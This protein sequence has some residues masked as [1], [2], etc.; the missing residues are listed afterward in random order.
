MQWMTIIS[1]PASDTRYQEN[2]AGTLARLTVGGR[3]LVRPRADTDQVYSAYQRYV[4]AEVK[5][6]GN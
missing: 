3:V 5:S 1:H 4:E 2:E 6:Y